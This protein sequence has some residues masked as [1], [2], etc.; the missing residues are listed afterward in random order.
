MTFEPDVDVDGSPA[1]SR[2]CKEI[3]VRRFGRAERVGETLNPVR[4]D[5]L[6]KVLVIILA[7]LQAFW[8]IKKIMYTLTAFDCIDPQCIV[9]CN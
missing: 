4:Q 8:G 3:G 6:T 5:N 7:N 9:T 2:G 1:V